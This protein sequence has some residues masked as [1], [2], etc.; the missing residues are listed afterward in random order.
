MMLFVTDELVPQGNL[1]WNDH[2]FKRTVQLNKT[3][4]RNRK[5]QPDIVK[6][7]PWPKTPIAFYVQACVY[8]RRKTV[9]HFK[10]KTNNLFNVVLEKQEKRICNEWVEMLY[11]IYFEI[12]RCNRSKM[13]L[14]FTALLW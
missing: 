3:E 8:Y 13:G 2:G 1:F 12:I 9:V 14:G 7:G 6:T 4:R 5:I 10:T 11:A